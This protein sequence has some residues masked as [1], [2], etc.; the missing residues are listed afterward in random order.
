MSGQGIAKFFGRAYGRIE[1]WKSAARR[2]RPGIQGGPAPR[3]LLR[4]PVQ[5]KGHEKQLTGS[6]QN[7]A[8]GGMLIE[9]DGPLS[10]GEPVQIGFKLPDGPNISIPAVV[11]RKQ[12]PTLAIRF[13]VT[14]PQRE[15]I[16]RWV[17]SQLKPAS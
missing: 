8:M 12:N 7:I 17:E 13:D 2:H 15:L 11:C 3:V 5:I 1:K 6:S 9:A 16:Q 14:D 10:V 4:M